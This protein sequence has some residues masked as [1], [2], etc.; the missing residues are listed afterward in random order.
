MNE[1]VRMPLLAQALDDGADFLGVGDPGALEAMHA[2]AGGEA[3]PQRRASTSQNRS[4][5]GVGE[6]ALQD[7]YR[8][9][10][11]LRARLDP[12]GL[13]N[14]PVVAELAP[15]QY[16]L[17]SET[18][19]PIVA[20]LERAYCGS[21][22]WEFGTI[23]DIQQRRW[24]EAQAESTDDISPGDATRIAMLALLARAEAFESGLNQ[25]IPGGKLF[26]L[27]GA[28]TFLVALDTIIAES[29]RQGVDEVV[30]GGMHRGRFAMIAT[31]LGKPLGPLIAEIL[32]KPAVPDGLACSSDVSYHLG[33]SGDIDSAGKRVHLSV[34]PHPSH[35]QLAPLIAQG[36][37]RAKQTSRGHAG[38]TRVLPLLLHTDASF[39][40]SRRCCSCRASPRSISAAPFT[41]SSTISLASRRSLKR[42]APPGHPSISPA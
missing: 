1:H 22:G 18:A 38:H 3:T 10:G 15:A 5:S 20:R 29:A 36:R 11:F 9:R 25:R 19:A 14:V 40:S 12:L 27:G 8:T 24:L 6:A 28:E 39:A 37:A 41:S 17:G 33:Y 2:A 35:L 30:I 16:G 32:G 7:A 31:V 4:A 23:H 26:G 21:I 34:S 13:A 42:A